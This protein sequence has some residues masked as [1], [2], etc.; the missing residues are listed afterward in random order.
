MKKILIAITRNTGEF[1]SFWQQNLTADDNKIILP[2]KKF[3]N[4]KVLILVY[5]GNINDLEDFCSQLK[6]ILSNQLPSDSEIGVIYHGDISN[7]MVGCLTA[8]GNSKISFFKSYSSSI[9][10][11]TDGDGSNFS[12]TPCSGTKPLDKLRD[13][14]LENCQNTN[15]SGSFDEVWNFFSGDPILESNLNHLHSEWAAINFNEE[16]SKQKVDSLTETRNKMLKP[17]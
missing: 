11:L 2:F 7:K 16:S 6:Q 15:F 12:A 5:G 13:S 1:D 14:I 3:V 4:D 8:D 10:G 17:Y 9:T